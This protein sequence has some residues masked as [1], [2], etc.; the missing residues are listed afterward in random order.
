MSER[1]VLMDISMKSEDQLLST[2]S[3]LGNKN[4]KTFVSTEGPQKREHNL[5]NMSI[6]E[7]RF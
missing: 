5:I 1:N 7:K 3:V 2:P 4:V 6:I